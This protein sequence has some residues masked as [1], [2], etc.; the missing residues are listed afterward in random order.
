M[1]SHESNT[2][3]QSRAD[4]KS[5]PSAVK[6]VVQEL[7]RCGYVEEQRKPAMF[8]TAMTSDTEI[9]SALEPV[10]LAMRL[11]EHRGVAFLVVAEAAC[12]EGSEGVEWSHPLVR[13]QRLT[14]EQSLLIALLRQTFLLHEQD[15][16]VGGASAKVAVDEL[17]PQFLSYLG[18][19]GSDTKNQNRLTTLLDQLKTYGIVSEV[20]KNEELTIRPLIAH[21]AN[22]ESLKALLAALEVEA[23]AAG[24]EDRGA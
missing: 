2:E 8:R 14:L 13:R 21:L 10:D 17:L 23:T 5:T 16:G 6:E 9:S 4:A 19:S 12:E 15:A 11:D 22:P 7:L 24:S 1:S 18:D 20:D 3:V